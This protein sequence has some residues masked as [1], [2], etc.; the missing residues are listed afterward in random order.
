MPIGWPEGPH[1]EAD[2]S[3]LSGRTAAVIGPVHLYFG[4]PFLTADRTKVLKV[5]VVALEI[6]LTWMR[7]VVQG[8]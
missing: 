5:D 4:L 3:A 6:V 1:V 8:G 2:E 7:E